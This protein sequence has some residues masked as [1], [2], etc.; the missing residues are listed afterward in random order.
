MMKNNP[1]SKPHFE[2]TIVL[3]MGIAGVGK[4][5]IAQAMFKMDNSFRFVPNDSWVDPILNL[6]GDEPTIMNT[7]TSEGWAALEKSSDV[8]FDTIINVCPKEFNFAITNE[9]LE[10]NIWHQN[11]YKKVE[12]MADKRNAKFIPVRLIADVA[13]LAK[14]VVSEDRKNF[15]K[16]RDSNMV[17]ERAISSEVLKSKNK[18]ELT[19]DTTHLSPLE[20]AEKIFQHLQQIH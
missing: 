18:N 17:K 3:L 1:K 19:L 7:L 15:F 5:T 4:R 11:F 16:T 9:L 8:I 12:L 13:V 14:R 2:N 10:G 20:S 6:L